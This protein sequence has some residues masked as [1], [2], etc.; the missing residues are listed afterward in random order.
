M[1]GN[2]RVVNKESIR[3]LVQYKDWSD[4]KFDKYYEQILL[5]D[6]HNKEELNEKV[7]VKIDELAKDYDID[8]LKYNDKMQLND[9]ATA[10]VTL[11]DLQGILYEENIKGVVVDNIVFIERLSKIISSIRGDIS[12]IQDDLRLSRKIRK[13]EKEESVLIY[14]EKIREQAKRKFE[15]VLSYIYCPKCRMLLSNAWFLYPYMDNS[16]QLTCN[17]TLKDGSKCGNIFTVTSKQLMD[18][19]GCNIKG[20]F[21]GK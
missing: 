3:N 2:V 9:L 17:R 14:I 15:E 11:E 12:K 18:N 6:L 10:M 4:E 19:S 8:D 16:I 7:K 1:A 13:S 20:V 5:K 21:P